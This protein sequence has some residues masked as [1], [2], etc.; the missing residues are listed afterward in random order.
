MK[1]KLNEALILALADKDKEAKLRSI[2]LRL[3]LLPK[4]EDYSQVNADG[5]NPKIEYLELVRY[6]IN[7][8]T[9]KVIADI[10]KV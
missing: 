1:H 2:C 7:G 9:M 10:L 5:S 3:S 4:T 6:G 8:C